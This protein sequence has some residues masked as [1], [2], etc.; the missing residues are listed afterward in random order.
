MD[1][2]FNASSID[3]TFQENEIVLGESGRFVFSKKRIFGRMHFLKRP[4]GKYE[5]D[6]VTFE[7]L[8]KEFTIGYALDHPNIARYI[9]FEDNVLYE[10]FIDGKSLR[11]LIEADDP[12]LRDKGFLRNLCR[13][14]LDALL[15]LRG[16][17][18]VHNDIKPENVIVTR[19]GNTVKLVDFNCAQSADNDA[20]GGYTR[21]YRAPEQGLSGKFDTTSDLYQVGKIMEELSA[22]AGYPKRWRR[23]VAGATAYNPAKRISLETAV[24]LIP[25]VSKPNRLLWA[26][27]PL[28][29]LGILAVILFTPKPAE[30]DASREDKPVKDTVVV[31]KIQIIEPAVEPPMERQETHETHRVDTKAVIEK[32]ILDYTDSYYKTHLY[33]I[34]RDVL[35]NNAGRLS[36]E[37]ELELQKA[38]EKA[39]ASARE[40]GVKLSSEYP[41]ER[42]YIEKECLQSFEMKISG[43]LLKVYPPV[44]TGPSDTAE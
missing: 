4:S 44:D 28:I 35:E 29:I 13:Q 36:R 25:G 17:G 8:R 21:R 24:G 15:Y 37:K 23:F 3:E 34:C 20:V 11:E 32:K 1:S 2:E 5:N 31:E 19:I 22:R 7:S 33:P 14:F 12:R 6:L 18:V 27:F 39:Y 40:Y 38:I 30:T 9:R 42:N 16:T 26:I 43:L 41:G 10:E